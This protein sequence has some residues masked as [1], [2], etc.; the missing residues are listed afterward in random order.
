[1]LKS[2]TSN[3]YSLWRAFY[4]LEPFGP[5]IE[6]RQS[7]QIANILANAHSEKGKSFD[8]QE[9]MVSDLK[10]HKPDPEQV[11]KNLAQMAKA[12]GARDLR[13]KED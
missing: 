12:A 10:E 2:M 11:G 5:L 9:L 13:D 3:E 8:I 4:E 7:A 1:M 6:D